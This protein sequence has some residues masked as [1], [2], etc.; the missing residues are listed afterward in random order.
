ML[1]LVGSGEY[2]PEMEIVDHYLLDRP[3]WQA[4]QDVVARGGVLAGCSTGAMVLGEKIPGFPRAQRA[5]NLLE[6]AVVVPHFDEIPSWTARLIRLLLG[7]NARMVGILGYTAL[8]V[9]GYTCKVLG[10]PEIQLLLSQ[11]MSIISN[12]LDS[13]RRL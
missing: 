1:A 7:R 5:F 12:A 10:K 13:T 8:L 11:C 3:V 6:G 4:I 2:L 9:N